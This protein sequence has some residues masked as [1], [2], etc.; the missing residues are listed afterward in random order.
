M[1]K[2][3]VF[4]SFLLLFLDQLTKYWV[5]TFLKE[6]TLVLIPNFFSFDLVYNTGGAFSL[7]HQY[8]YLLIAVSILSLIFL[9]EFEKDLLDSNLKT[10]AFSLLYGGVLGNLGDRIFVGSVRDFLDFQFFQTH[11]PTFNVADVAIVLGMICLFLL[12]FSR[13]GKRYE[14]FPDC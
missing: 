3:I 8:P 9:H 6:T 11:F 12:L 1:K 13:K 2:K 14:N 4:G 5:E 7:F 10:I